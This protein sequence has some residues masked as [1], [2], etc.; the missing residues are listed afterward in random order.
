MLGLSRAFGASVASGISAFLPYLTPWDF[1][2][3][4]VLVCAVTAILY[5]RGLAA[6]RQRGVHPGFWRPFSFLLGLALIYGV[7]QTYFYF[8]SQHMFWI[9][10]LQHLVL[11]HLAPFLMVIALP[12]PILRAGIPRRWRG[13]EKALWHRAGIR[14][15]MAL[16]QNPLMAGFLFV[17]L[18]Y[19]W[20]IPAI[21]FTAMLD[22]D[23]YRLMN[24]SMAV[25]G[26]L[27]WWLMLTPRSAQGSAAVAYGPRVT[28]LVVTG[29]LQLFLGF[30]FVIQK[31]T[32]FTVYGVC[33]RAWA[34]SPLVDQ[35]IG[36]CITW[37]PP[38]MM[39][40]LGVLVV[41][42]HALHDQERSPVKSQS[43]STAAAA[44][45]R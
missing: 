10:R 9:H 13:A 26:V 7:L 29:F 45:A 24:W 23:R 32:L 43:S 8:L 2:P 12:G 39:S 17:G 11:H 19:F 40:L 34:I 25:D 36:G 33:G 15:V 18:I 1:S 4:V 27:F 5:I 14:Q 16:L 38:A 41:I 30:Y 3:T 31:T 28:V 21:H 22:A 20:L 42:H 6:V 35:Q 37:I 44:A